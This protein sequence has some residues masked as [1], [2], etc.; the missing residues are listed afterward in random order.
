MK[1]IYFH[2]V[3]VMILSFSIF[4]NKF[5]PINEARAEVEKGKVAQQV[6]VQLGQG[7][8]DLHAAI[9]ALK[10][11]NGLQAKG[12]KVTL[13]LNLEAVRFADKRQV[14][15]LVWGHTNGP[16]VQQL[17]DGFVGKGGSIMICPMC[18]EAAGLDEKNLRKG[19]KIPKSED[20]IISAILNADKTLSY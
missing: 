1:R 9:M 10:L 18:A 7:T 11:S 14:Q 3:L 20:E 6:F 17:Y 13:F 15:N 5:L 8:N 12:A 4:G 19:A 16:S 2:L